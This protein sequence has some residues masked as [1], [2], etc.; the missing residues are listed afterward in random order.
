MRVA[1]VVRGCLLLGALC[2]ALTAQAQR[3]SLPGISRAFARYQT[4]ALQ[5]K[6]FL[7]TDRPAYV[8]GDILWFKLY[9]VDATYHRP[10][11]LSKIAY[12]EVLDRQ[13]KPVLQTKIA[14][15][16]AIG[17]G[18]LLLPA[19]LVSGSY[20]VR[21]YTNWMKNTGPEYYFHRSITVVNTLAAALPAAVDSGRYDVQFFPEGGQLV[22]GL[23]SRVAFKITDKTGRGIAAEGSLL[24]GSGAT[25]AR[26]AT[27]KF[28]MGHVDFTPSQ[29]GAVYTAVVKLADGQPLTHK[30]P[31]VHA[32]GH[33]LRLDEAADHVAV[34]VQAAVPGAGTVYLLG[35]AGQ[36][37]FASV[38]GQLRNG[39]AQFTVANSALPEGVLHF[40]VFN[41][42][43]QPVAERLYFRRPGRPL[44]LQL[45][46]DK[47]QYGTREKV[48]LAVT[49]T[50]AAQQPQPAAN[51]SL[52]VYKLDSLAAAPGTD[53]SSYLW[54]A[55]DLQG[56]V[57]QP[58]YYVHAT[59][60]E[61]AEATDNLMLT[62]GWRRFTWQDV[63]A[64]QP[65]V[66]AYVPEL[67]GHLIRGRVVQAATGA[68]APGIA[69]FLA[70]PSRYLRLYNSISKPDG[71]IQFEVRDFSGPRNPVVQPD[72][73][74]DST[75]RIEL[76]NPFSTEYTTTLRPPLALDE[77]HRAALTQRHLQMQVQN[78]YYRQ[79]RAPR[80]QPLADSTAFYGQPAEHYRLDDYTRFKVMEEVMREYVPGVQVRIR[81][82]GFN[83][84]VLNKPR[85]YFFPENP[86]VLLDGVPIFDMNKVL[87]IDPLQVQTLDVVTS[88]Y[89]QGQL[90]YSG[91]VSYR[92]YKGDMANHQLDARALVQE[93]EGVQWQR[94]FYAPRYDTP[95]DQQRRLPDLRNLLYWNPAVLT[96]ASGASQQ[97]WYT[98]D[99]AGTYLVVV[100]GLGAN[101]QSGSATY[102]FEVK[103]ADVARNK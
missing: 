28:G 80:P 45:K 60:A 100:Q 25:V 102:R 75:Y 95:N 1:Y 47:A 83:Y 73:S 16:N 41:D 76:L 79:Y 42:Q 23:K 96:D 84:M 2:M 88:G 62:Q 43:R 19:S 64:A 54:L 15:T 89:Q 29:P 77:R 21:A 38:A 46:T 72:L 27:L 6:L 4:Q 8:S 14:L 63:L 69:T 12:V 9:A 55:A 26:F 30:L 52:A 90:K 37:V 61:V 68:P 11:P 99:E 103:Q 32:Q 51:L 56:A 65:P 7:H 94:E 74:R 70:S 40:T 31:P 101:G 58:E 93:Y 50:G 22:Q 53:I 71:S 85:N 98:A 67:N 78:A 35:H 13:Q 39:Q 81:K 86:M 18:S 17:S 59:G 48:S 91:L 20:T 33:V 24:D 36:Q 44:Q 34:T 5:E 87:K 66:P 57:E 82:N 97:T 3:D 49:A 92:T 10:L